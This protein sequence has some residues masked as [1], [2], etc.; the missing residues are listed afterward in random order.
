VKID[1]VEFVNLLTYPQPESATC[2]P[3]TR[4]TSGFKTIL[5]ATRLYQRNVGS[6]VTDVSW[7]GTGTGSE[8]I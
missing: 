5:A 3:T 4:A 2:L 8:R 6:S 7:N 1:T